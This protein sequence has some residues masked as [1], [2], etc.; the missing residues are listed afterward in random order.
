MNPICYYLFVYAIEAIVL[1]LYCNRLFEAKRNAFLSF[2]I[3]ICFFLLLIPVSILGNAAINIFFSLIIYFICIVLIYNV[4]IYP[5]VFHALAL[6]IIMVLSEGLIAALP[7]IR[8]YLYRENNIYNSSDLTFVILSKSVYLLISQFATRIFDKHKYYIKNDKP[9]KSILMLY[10]IPVISSVI[11]LLLSSVCT[12]ANISYSTNIIIFICLTLLLLIN[13]LTFYLQQEISKKNTEY[14]RLQ[15]ELQKENDTVEHY[16]YI[17]ENDE[18]LHI[19]IHDIKNHLNTIKNLNDGSHREEISQYIN[20]ILGSETLKKSKRYCNIDILNIIISRYAEKCSNYNIDFEA[21]IR[22][23]TLGY[24]PSEDFT[25][26]FCNLLD[27]AIESAIH[28]NEPYID[29]NVSLIRGGNA[30]LISIANSCDASP[31]GSDGKLHSKKHDNHLHGYGLKSVKR[32]ADKYNGLLN[33]IYSEEKH[34][35]RIVV[36]LEHPQ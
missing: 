5:A 21:D 9:Q 15:T 27:N 33:Y 32:I 10:F 36:M 2:L 16:R 13:I 24:L 8:I 1:W 22:S 3:T 20:N 4:K 30:D 34:E 23:N 25:S 19:L 31:S 26:I 12:N 17:K 29:C 11:T 28:S 6:T 18:K 35:F 7:H 14:A